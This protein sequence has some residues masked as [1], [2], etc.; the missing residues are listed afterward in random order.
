VPPALLR[1]DAIR[2]RF[3]ISDGWTPELA[4]DGRFSSDRAAALA[5][6]L[7]PLVRR[8]DGLHVLLTQR[9]AHL[10]N[11]PGQISFPGGKAEPGDRDLEATALREAQEEVGLDRRHVEIIGR[12]PSYT[13][14]TSFVVTPVVALVQPPFDLTPDGREV[15][16][17]FEV[18]LAFLMNPAHHRRH[19]YHYDGGSRQFLS[20]PWRSSPG[21][22]GSKEFFIWG[23][24]ASMLRNF[25]RLLADAPP[26]GVM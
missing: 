10:K 14:V 22:G 13:T 2:A 4:G 7:V 25:Y 15:A 20:M 8:D 19:F 6:V 9:T 16:E 1:L 3:P 21:A 11:H 5:A 17:V 12:L 24:T 18:P 23:A 26:V